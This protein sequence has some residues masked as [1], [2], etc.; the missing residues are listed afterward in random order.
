LRDWCWIETELNPADWATKPKCAT[1]LGKGSFWQQGPS[2]LTENFEDWP[3]RQ[4]FKVEG[5]IRPTSTHVVYFTSGNLDHK[6]EKLLQRVSSPQKLFR[7]V[8]VMFKWRSLK[9][10][11]SETSI[12][13]V[14]SAYGIKLAKMFWIRFV[15]KTI[16]EDMQNFISQGDSS[17]IHG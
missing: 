13:G 7:I 1:E 17:K 6:M 15:Q 9:T 5:E 2:F 4:D 10:K 3:V 11:S 8:A 16:E 12:P 14:V